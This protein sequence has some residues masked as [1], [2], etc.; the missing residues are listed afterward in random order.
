MPKP[1]KTGSYLG[2]LNSKERAEASALAR[3]FLGE[4]AGQLDFFEDRSSVELAN[5]RVKEVRLEVSDV[6]QDTLF[7][8][9]KYRPAYPSGS[10]KSIEAAQTWVTA[11]VT[12]YNTDHRHCSIRF[13]TP[14]ER[15]DGR[16]VEILAHRH[17]VY[18][19][20][21]ARHPERWAGKTRNWNPIEEVKLNP[22]IAIA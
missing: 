18:R 21:R 15:H 6:L 2:D 12:W 17:M 16:D 1:G 3:H 13:V 22:D 4:R 8:T 11:F 7:R 20:A 14:A 10:F 9:L 5:V 19:E